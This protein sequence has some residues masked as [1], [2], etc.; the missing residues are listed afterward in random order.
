MAADGAERELTAYFNLSRQPQSV[1]EADRP[2]GKLLLSS[3]EA[4]FGGS[5]GPQNPIDTLLPYE[6]WVFGPDPE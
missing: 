5:R 6:F 4:R 3:E 1:P 2:E